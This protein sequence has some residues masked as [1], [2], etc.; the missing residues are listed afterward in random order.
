METIRRSMRRFF[1]D[2]KLSSIDAVDPNASDMMQI[3]AICST[4][5]GF[6]VEGT[7]FD[8]SIDIVPPHRAN[9][10]IHTRREFKSRV[11]GFIENVVKPGTLCREV[12]EAEFHA[13]RQIL[14]EK[15]QYLK[16]RKD[17]KQ[18][19]SEETTGARRLP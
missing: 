13:L 8:F 7:L 16:T 11:E 6:E 14:L 19:F 12:Q 1:V 10:K 15:S 9:N 5:N 18:V 2:R 17:R 3:V 4:S